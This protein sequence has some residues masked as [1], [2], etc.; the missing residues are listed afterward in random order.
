MP[1]DLNVIAATQGTIKKFQGVSMAHKQ[2]LRTTIT[3]TAFK[4]RQA[5]T[6]ALQTKLNRPL[7]YIFRAYVYEPA[8]DL[9]NPRARIFIKDRGRIR[10]LISTVQTGEHIPTS[11]TKWG[12]REGIIHGRESLVATRQAKR[13]SKGNLSPSYV[14]RVRQRGVVVRKGS[15]RGIY[16]KRGRKLQKIFTPAI[17]SRYRPPVNVFG[18]LKTVTQG[19]TAEYN[20]QVKHFVLRALSR[21]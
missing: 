12:K 5:I 13:T 16:L 11:I 1:I 21:P 14:R 17:I 8:T 18:V 4:G 9:E 15:R 2:A 10:Y 20:A 6:K 7:P 3:R 19:F